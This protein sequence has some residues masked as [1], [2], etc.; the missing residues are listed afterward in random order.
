[1]NWKVRFFILTAEDLTYWDEYGGNTNPSAKKR[2]TVLVSQIH[3]AEEV[4]DAAFE[5][6]FMM[7]VVYGD[8]NYVLYIQCSDVSERQE[9]LNHIRRLIPPMQQNQKFHPGY[10]D[11]KWTCC[12]DA[13]KLTIGCQPCS[14]PSGYGGEHTCV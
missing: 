12:S 7:Q 2:G 3:A 9:W 4:P 8:N 10:Y 13:N 1:M 11:G 14:P 5:R 6:A